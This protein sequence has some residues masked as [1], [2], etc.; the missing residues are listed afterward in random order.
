MQSQELKTLLQMRPK[1]WDILHLPLTWYR[2][3][4]LWWP[5]A[6][7]K[8][9]KENVCGFYSICHARFLASSY[10][11]RKYIDV[12]LKEH[13]DID[14]E[15]RLAQVYSDMGWT[16]CDLGHPDDGI[17]LLEKS[18]AVGETNFKQTTTW[19]LACRL[20][21]RKDSTKRIELLGS[22]TNFEA[23]Q[24]MLAKAYLDAGMLEKANEI[25]NSHASDEWHI[26][27]HF[28][29]GDLYFAQQQY[30]TA[31]KE[32]G[33]YYFS[34]SLYFWRYEYDYKEALAYYYS[35]QLENCRKQAFRIRRRKK[36]D[37]FYCMYEL[38]SVGIKREK[39]IDD[40]IASE[41][42]DSQFADYERVRYYA[43]ALWWLACCHV[44]RLWNWCGRNYFLSAF[45][46]GFLLFLFICW[47]TGRPLLPRRW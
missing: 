12:V 23:K 32:Y 11:D 29:W 35:S 45:L 13:F 3:A 27:Y 26:W 20:N 22:V 37:K 6:R 31:A 30:D 5:S 38:D 40:I 4:I 44:Q 14:T 17:T 7:K 39:F 19:M 33:K 9:L 24:P 18:I 43:S 28:L 15:S 21:Q 16:L 46:C 42:S 34:D 25:L 41:Q 10:R 36:W 47:L 8:A 2:M 1:L